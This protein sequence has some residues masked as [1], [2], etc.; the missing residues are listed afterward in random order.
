MKV[1]LCCI[2]KFENKYIREFV[3]Y[4]YNLG[5]DHIF[6]YDTN[7]ENGDHIEDVINDYI[8]N[9]FVEKI[10]WKL[11]EPR[12]EVLKAYQD[13]YDNRLNDYDWCCFFDPDEYLTLYNNYNIKDYLSRD[14]FNN[15][16]LIL[17]NWLNMSDNNLIYYDDRPLTNRFT[18][19]CFNPYKFKENKKI[20]SIIKTNLKDID[21]L[22][23]RAHCPLTNNIKVLNNGQIYFDSQF[24]E[25]EINQI[26]FDDAALKHFRCKTIEEYFDKFKKLTQYGYS[27]IIFD[28]NFFV[29]Y[30]EDTLE[31]RKIYENFISTIPNYNEIIKETNERKAY[32]KFLNKILNKSFTEKSKIKLNF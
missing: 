15:C 8:N 30:N 16:G 17:I 1:A 4:Y 20:K 7:D 3:E 2:E 6:M 23:G 19:A 5:I 14:I 12:I 9:G 11:N 26:N 13:C 10:E 31:K 29:L 27:E 18:R 21:W 24:C 32:N 25:C 22:K 28:Y